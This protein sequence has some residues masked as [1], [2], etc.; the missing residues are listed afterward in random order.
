[1]SISFDR[2]AATYDET[3]G[4]EGRG[5]NC[6]EA[7]AP[8]FANSGLT[9]EIGAGTGVV[10]AALRARKWRVVGVDISEAM[11][12]RAAGRGLPVVR[13]DAAALPFASNSV[14]DAYSVWMLHVV[15]DQ[16]AVIREAFRVLRPGGRYLMEL[17]SRYEREGDEIARIRAKMDRALREGNPP[18]D[19]AEV[20]I[21]M[22][23][24][25]GFL[26]VGIVER[27]SDVF[28]E[29]PMD[30]VAGIERRDA[31]ILWNVDGDMWRVAV[32]P[33]LAALRALPEPT[34]PRERHAV[35]EI[36]VLEKPAQ[37]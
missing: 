10:G 26:L 19:D 29:S 32:E 18:R 31:T 11:L 36:V 34:R 9:L 22:A 23:V 4:G 14:D 1:M 5:V 12:Q 27:T 35:H 17:T 6:C 3:R 37:T 33:A 24:Q 30:A 13:A 28:M 7:L 20:M 25:A 2:V 21:R 16:A 8:L 15:A